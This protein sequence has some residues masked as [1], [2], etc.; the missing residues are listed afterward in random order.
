MKQK[1]ETG[2][3]QKKPNN[4]NFEAWFD[5][6]TALH[7]NDCFCLI[8]IKNRKVYLQS[9]GTNPAYIGFDEEKPEYAG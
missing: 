8:R 3:G 4:I 9:C 2:A 1:K 6:I 7:G 5:Q